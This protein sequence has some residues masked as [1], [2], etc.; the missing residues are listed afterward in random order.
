MAKQKARDAK[1]AADIADLI[2]ILE[3]LPP[4]PMPWAAVIRLVAPV[5]SRL[6]VRMALKRIARGMS[7]T[8]IKVITDA[9]AKII[10]V[11]TGLSKVEEL[12]KK[13]IK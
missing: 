4:N 6:A 3:A 13:R 1:I 12:V 8:R 2:N 10:A 5:I 9:I 7:E 11:A